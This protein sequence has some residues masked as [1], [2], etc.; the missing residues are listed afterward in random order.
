[1]TEQLSLFAA[2]S[3]GFLS[4]LS[5]CVLPL[6]VPYLCYMTGL[7][8]EDLRFENKGHS[9]VFTRLSLLRS[10]IAFILGFS[11]IF[12]ILGASATTVGHFLNQYRSLFSIFAGIIIFLMG[13]HFLGIF[14]LKILYREWR[15]NN[16]FQNRDSKKGLLPSYLMGLAFAFGWSP[17]MGPI[18]GPI[19]A[20]A[21]GKQTVI[22]GIIF[23]SFY[24]L[25]LGIPFLLAALFSNIFLSFFSK[26][27]T[28]LHK[29]EKL[30][31]LLLVLTG[32]L[33]ITG[34]IEMVSYWLLEKLP[35][36][37]E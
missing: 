25:G 14:R 21:S 22:D 10:S 35:V 27:R 29:I 18:L 8:L 13:C 23:L 1:M 4:F 5:P 28:Y 34:Q 17:C 12:I 36:I 15:F 24:C 20:L 3:A 9:K 2:Y 31:G 11:T 33:F 26:F 19:L 30:I 16:F 7:T 6:V 32:I 37:N